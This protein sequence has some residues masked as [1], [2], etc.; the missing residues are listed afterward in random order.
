MILYNITDEESKRITILRAICVVFVLYLHQYAGGLNNTNFTVTGIVLDNPVLDAVQYTISRIITF[1]AVPMFFLISSVLLYSKEFTWKSN[2][3]KKLKS[4]VLPYLLWITI[5]IL[6]YCIGQGIPMTSSYF[7]NENRQIRN[8]RVM[9]FIGAYTGI[10]GNGLF[11]NSFW[12]LRDLIFLNIFAAGIKKIIDKY[13][14][15]TF[16][17]ILMLWNFGDVPEIL[18]INKQS[19]VFFC[20]GYYIVKYGIRMNKLDNFSGLGGGVLLYLVIIEIEYHFYSV[21]SVL[22]VPVHS[23]SVFIGMFLLVKL[24]KKLVLAGRLSTVFFH[25]AYYSFFIYVTADLLQTILKKMALKVLPLSNSFQMIEYFLIPLIVCSICL[26][27]GV[28]LDHR[29]HP[30]YQVLTGSRRNES[31]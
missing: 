20:L 28:F 7:A 30:V 31:K 27:C 25:I 17:L 13:P 22:R 2:M 26:I 29:M 5:Y 19:I 16:T 10:G 11:V 9:D 12:F 21:D 18:I 8:M 24:S 1:T 4:L 6:I 23:F 14:L 15:L 3:N